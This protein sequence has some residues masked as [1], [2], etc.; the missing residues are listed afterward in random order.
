MS[1][2]HTCPLLVLNKLTVKL[3]GSLSQLAPLPRDTHELKADQAEWVREKTEMVY[4]LL[5]E[6]PPDG[7]AFVQTV[8]H[9]LKVSSCSVDFHCQMLI[10]KIRIKIKKKTY[11]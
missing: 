10:L 1:G 11:L 3:S 5:E 2:G 9:I 6:T 7:T 4:S 8:K